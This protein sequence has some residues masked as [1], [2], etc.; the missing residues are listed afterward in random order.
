MIHHKTK[1]STLSPIYSR[2]NKQQETIKYSSAVK[3]KSI[4]NRI[5]KKFSALS[6]GG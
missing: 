4:E 2:K 5:L 3:V 6:I 1:S